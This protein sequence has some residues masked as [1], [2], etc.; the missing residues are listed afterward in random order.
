ME[1]DTTQVATHKPRSKHCIAELR[2]TLGE[3]C[4]RYPLAFNLELRNIPLKIGIFADLIKACP[5]KS[6]KH[7]RFALL[8]YTNH[9]DYQK[10]II[11]SKHRFDLDGVAVSDIKENDRTYAKGLFKHIKSVWKARKLRRLERE[12]QLEKPPEKPLDVTIQASDTIT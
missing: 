2:K 3:L 11:E 9:L 8:Y 5:D 1:Q 12:A 10:C 6:R 4:T 7:L